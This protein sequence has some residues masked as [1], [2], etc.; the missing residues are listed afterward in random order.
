[1]NDQASHHLIYQIP[2]LC[3]LLN[4]ELSPGTQD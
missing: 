2:Q 4:S 3:G 1:V